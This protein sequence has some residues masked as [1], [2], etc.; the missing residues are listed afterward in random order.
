MSCSG[1]TSMCVCFFSAR[2]PVAAISLP[3]TL[4]ATW[5]VRALL[6]S[7]TAV[8]EHIRLAPI[9]PYLLCGARH[10]RLRAG[11]SG[12]GCRRFPRGTRSERSLPPVRI[13]Q[14][15]RFAI[16]TFMVRALRCVQASWCVR[17]PASPP[18]AVRNATQTRPV[19][20]VP[21]CAAPTVLPCHTGRLHER[22]R[23]G[24][25]ERRH[26]TARRVG[27]DV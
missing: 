3:C 2:K 20:R 14:L 10:G 9:C 26:D 16:V 22:T 25:G 11:N 15:P 13:G 23:V 8:T 4:C 24:H 6:E 18:H 7:R 12:R 5:R 21:R 1:K 17:N 19:D 27:R